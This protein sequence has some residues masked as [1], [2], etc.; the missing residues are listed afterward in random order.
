MDSGEGGKNFIKK[1]KNNKIK[2]NKIKIKLVRIS[3]DTLGDKNKNYVK[4]KL[5]ICL[6]KNIDKNVYYCVIACHSASS[7]ILE[8]LMKSNFSYNNIR[9]YEPIIPTCFYIKKMKFKNIL[10]LS[11]I[12]TQ[13]IGWHKRLLDSADKNIKYLTFP[14]LA[15]EIENS[16]KDL[17]KSLH[18]LSKKKEFIKK[19]DCIVLGC[20]HYNIIKLELLKKLKDNY[21]FTG[22]LIDSNE[23]ILKYITDK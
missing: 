14:L 21:D 1:I 12:L 6:N 2:N 17:S 8:E 22:T 9:I 20:T 16:K 13:K 23:M 4:K 18:R 7:C 11:T 10:I 3:K 15:K 5:L 19:C